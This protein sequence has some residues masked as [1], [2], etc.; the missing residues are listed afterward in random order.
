MDGGRTTPW[1]IAHRGQI[2]GKASPERELDWDAVVK[3]AQILSCAASRFL[4]ASGTAAMNTAV[5]GAGP[6]NPCVHLA[7]HSAL[8][9][10]GCC[11]GFCCSGPAGDAQR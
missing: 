10:G 2:R 6:P 11:W 3:V 7:V 5:S 8:G 1:V 9:V 4:A